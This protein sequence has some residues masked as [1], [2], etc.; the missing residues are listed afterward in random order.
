MALCRDAH[1]QAGIGREVT[2][3]GQFL[4]GLRDACFINGGFDGIEDGIP[5]DALDDRAPAVGK[6]GRACGRGV[7]DTGG[8]GTGGRTIAEEKE[9]LQGL[10]GGLVRFEIETA[11]KPAAGKAGFQGV[12]V[13]EKPYRLCRSRR[14]DWRAARRP[15]GLQ[16]TAE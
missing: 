2:A 14:S 3:D 4:I 8:T 12:N 16:V 5:N 1:V 9:Q 15:G 6:R 7:D 13:N 10:T 11:E